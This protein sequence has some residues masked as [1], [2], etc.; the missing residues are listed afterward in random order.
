MHH[1]NLLDRIAVR[2]N[3][4]Y[5]YLGQSAKTTAKVYAGILHKSPDVT[6]GWKVIQYM[7]IEMESQLIF[8]GLSNKFKLEDS[9]LRNY[10]LFEVKNAIIL[11]DYSNDRHVSPG[12]TV[13]I[14]PSDRKYVYPI[15]PPRP[16]G[17]TKK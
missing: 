9:T 12:D 11:K 15:L 6:V 8:L 14:A 13:C 5:L 16:D 1:P 3:P 2:I 4:R 7:Y 10:S 17:S